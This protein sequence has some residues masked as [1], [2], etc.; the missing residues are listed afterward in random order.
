[1]FTGLL[2][3][4]APFA[5][6]AWHWWLPALFVFFV[7]ACCVWQVVGYSHLLV[8]RGF[9]TLIWIDALLT[10]CK[11]AP[12]P[13]QN[14]DGEFRGGA[15]KKKKCTH[16]GI[17]R[18]MLNIVMDYRFVRIFRAGLAGFVGG[19]ITVSLVL[20]FMGMEPFQ[21]KDALVWL[22]VMMAV[23][24]PFLFCGSYVQYV[25]GITVRNTLMTRAVVFALLFLLDFIGVVIG[26][27]VAHHVVA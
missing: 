20:P 1:M 18:K 10:C 21:L 2:A 14:G 7:Y 12:M 25:F 4:A 26:C 13:P 22:I 5:G 6:A 15:E 17:F 19:W 23:T 27:F 3:L 8:P 9:F 11:K 24:G 16:S